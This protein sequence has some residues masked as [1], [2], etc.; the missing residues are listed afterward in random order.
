MKE[1]LNQCKACMKVRNIQL[2]TVNPYGHYKERVCI[3]CYK[4]YLGSLLKNMSIDTGSSFVDSIIN[5]KG[6]NNEK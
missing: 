1:K 4:N 5:I 6:N 2:Y 3:E